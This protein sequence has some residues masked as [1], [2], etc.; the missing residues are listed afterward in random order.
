MDEAFRKLQSKV[1][2]MQEDREKD[3]AKIKDLEA[4]LAELEDEPNI[5]PYNQ[6]SFHWPNS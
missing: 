2:N 4:R 1:G 6:V 3:K 5:P